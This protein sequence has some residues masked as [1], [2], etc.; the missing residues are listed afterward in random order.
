MNEVS[1]MMNSLKLD[2]DQ[3]SINKVLDKQL[4]E[5]NTEFDLDLQTSSLDLIESRFV[6]VPFR[7]IEKALLKYDFEPVKQVDLDEIKKAFIL[8]GSRILKPEH[9]CPDF[10]INIMP[11]IRGIKAKR[12]KMLYSHQRLIEKG[13]LPSA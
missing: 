4:K 6:G 12:V 10:Y 2:A 3:I 7:P 9:F 13:V 5:V 11:V 1:D 8:G